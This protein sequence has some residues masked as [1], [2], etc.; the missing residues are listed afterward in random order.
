[1]RCRNC[2]TEIADK[3]L[4][5]FRCGTATTEPMYKPAPPARRGG[6]PAVVSGL[7]LALLVLLAL[8]MGRIAAGDVPRILS[9]VAVVVALL[10]V[11]LRVWLRRR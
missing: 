3:A 10:V 8:Y 5:C 11:V 9:W 1:M 6:T 7:A 2:G 4:I